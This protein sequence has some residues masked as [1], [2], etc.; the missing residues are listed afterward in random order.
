VIY[1][2]AQGVEFTPTPNENIFVNR[3][4]WSGE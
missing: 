4:G 3:I 2:A 1:G